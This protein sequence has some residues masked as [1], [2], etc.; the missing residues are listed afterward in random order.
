MN[1]FKNN[2]SIILIIYGILFS[3]SL[4]S[5]T[6]T[7]ITDPGNAVVNEMLESGGGFWTDLNNDGW[8]DLFVANGN[9]TSQNNSLFIND[10]NG[11]FIKVLTGPVV[12]DGGSS[13]GGAFADY[14]N[15]GK[16]DLFVTNRNFF[17]NFLYSGNGDSTFTK[18]ITGS[19]INDSANSNSGHWVDIDLDG[20][21]DLF[22]INFQE[23][24]FLYLNNG[25]PFFDFTKIDTAAF[26]LDGNEF[27]I[28]AVWSD[29]NNDRLP[30][31]FKG[32]AG[33]QNDNL[34]RNNGDLTF[35][36]TVIADGRS[37]LGAS[38]GDYNND[39]NQDLFAANFLN[40][41]N[42]LYRNSGAPQY[43]LTAI[44][45]GV[46][47]NDGGSSVG[48]CWGDIDNDGDLDLFVC[49]DDFQNNFLY[50]NNGAPDYTFTK[51]SAGS[52]VNDGGNSFGCV[53]GD[54]NNDGALDLFVANRLNQKNFLYVNNGNSNNWIGIKCKGVISAKSAI[55]TKVRIKSQING[56][57]VW[58]LREIQSQSGYNSGNLILNFGLGTAAII[59]SLKIEWLSGTTTVFTNLQVNSYITVSEDGNI[60]SVKKLSISPDFFELKQNYPNPFNPVTD[61]G[62]NL[63]FNS[64]VS[65]KIY[66]IL[67]NEVGV[68]VDEY[69]NSGSHKVKFDVNRI[70]KGI[71]LSS[72]IYFY[73]LTSRNL[74]L[75][76][77]MMLVK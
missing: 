57:P 11:G 70:R 56:Q 41:N 27:S 25:Q 33:M 35:T 31:L 67:G 49:N 39:G 3:G 14:N 13:I 10:K 34:Y 23:N 63:P 42:I 48:S 60:T 18:I 44:N 40:Q 19:I 51:I 58:Q 15:D 36:K 8:L 5:Q 69:Q 55:G 61:I 2:F 62:Y 29:F 1:L 12:T 53:F 54:Y 38:W 37:T 9:L 30:D 32:N 47:S 76:K 28:D 77:K 52:V 73:K 50:M 6:F 24:D 64:F 16:S 68:L 71:S 59:D 74:S 7:K 21:L 43:E 4:Y 22:V 26:L 75:T 72:G 65:L 46:V 20:D 17:K 66:D 45:T